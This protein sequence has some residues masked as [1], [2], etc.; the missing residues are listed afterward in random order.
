MFYCTLSFDVLQ[1]FVLDKAAV[2]QKI[3]L[4]VIYSDNN[5]VVVNKPCGL[6]S[7]QGK[8]E[9]PSVL[10]VLENEFGELHPVNRLDTPASGLMLLARNRQTAAELGRQL[11]SGVI[12]KKYLCAVDSPP[13]PESGR[14]VHYIR[15]GRGNK[16]S[17]LKVPAEGTKKAEL[18]YRF[19]CATEKYSILEINL[20]T[21]RKHQIRSQLAAEGMH[22]KGD[23]KYGARRTNRGGGIHLH[24]WFLSFSLPFGGGKKEFFCEPPEDPVWAVLDLN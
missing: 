22:I 1:I 16:V 8:K 9:E 3:N 7:Q 6:M 11:S 15:E 21:G 18:E 12:I 14:F 20:L 23:I 5:V 24:S 4:M 17:A 2:K 19:K 13:T 10:S